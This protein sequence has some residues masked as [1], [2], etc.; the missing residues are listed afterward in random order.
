MAEVR[1]QITDAPSLGRLLGGE[2]RI[3]LNEVR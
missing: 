1:A 3:A 2:H